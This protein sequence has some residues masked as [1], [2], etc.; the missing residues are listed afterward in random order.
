MIFLSGQHS[1]SLPTNTALHA[2]CSA[3]PSVSSCTLAIPGGSSNALVSTTTM[4]VA[5]QQ[6][7]PDGLVYRQL[8]RCEPGRNCLE[9][10][11][12]RRGLFRSAMVHLVRPS[13]MLLADDNTLWIGMTK[14]TNGERFAK[15]QPY[16]CLTMFNTSTNS[17]TMLEPYLGDLTG[18]AGCYRAAQGVRGARRP[19]VH[20][21]HHRRLVDQQPVCDRDGNRCRTW[22]LWTRTPTA[23][24]PSTS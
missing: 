12:R 23:T 16:G 11:C 1:G 4:Y 14:C 18:I 19:G 2:D 15:G 6:L 10:D 8:D 21:P 9:H 22:R 24:T 13:R 3:T 17:V 20:L 7:Q 5:G